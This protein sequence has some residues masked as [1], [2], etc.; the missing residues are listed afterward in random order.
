LKVIYLVESRFTKRDYDRFGIKTLTERGNDV[1]VWDLSGWF[2]PAYFKKYSPPDLLPDGSCKI[3]L[4]KRDFLD[5]L[6][7]PAANSIFI[8]IFR[9]NIKSLAI[10]DYL[11]QKG[12]KYGFIYFGHYPCHSHISRLRRTLSD[13]LF[14]LKRLIDSIIVKLYTLMIL[15][16]DANFII[17]GGASATSSYIGPATKILK[18][19]TLDYDL[20]LSL[21]G[22]PK[23][24]HSE[25]YIVY[26]DDYGPNH[27]DDIGDNTSIDPAIYYE[28][29]NFF[30]DKLELELGMKVVIAPHP[31][32]DY[33]RI[34]NPFNGRLIT[35]Q[36]T[37]QSVKNSFL[38]V[39]HA[40][41]A[42]SFAVLYYKPMLFITTNLYPA[43]TQEIIKNMAG[44]FHKTPFDIS[45]AD[46]VIS[47]DDLKVNRQIYNSYK[48]LYIKESGTPEIKVWSLFADYLDS[49]K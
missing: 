29:L 32:S 13:P 49:I 41:T 33:K 19:H 26:L 2:R 30:F 43:Y 22:E 21:E 48:D 6:K 17:L 39:S 36:S 34:G 8:C 44:F 5:L 18:A 45:I 7:P 37:I 31:R 38:V 10:F 46:L 16:I 27:P 40:S 25:R 14:V 47:D 35:D 3:V 23:I 24:S 28:K 4:N 9:P 15:P 11:N 20:L 42:T 12:G 1:E